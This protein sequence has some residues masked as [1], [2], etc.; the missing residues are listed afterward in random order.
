VAAATPGA[1]RMPKVVGM[2]LATA[3]EVIKSAIADPQFVVRQA[4][5]VGRPPGIVISQSPAAGTE[6][7]PGAEVRLAVADKTSGHP[8]ADAPSG[9]AQA[10]DSVRR[11]REPVAWAL[12]V[13]AAVM[14]LV[15]AGQLFG[16]PGLGLPI[17]GGPPRGLGPN[18]FALRASEAE[19]QFVDWIVIAPPLVSLVLVAF[20]GGLTKHA[21]QVLKT[22]AAV[23]AGTLVFGAVSLAGSTGGFQQGIQYVYEG[24]GLAVTATALIFTA[25]VIRSQAVR[26]LASR[27]SSN[28]L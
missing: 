8:G 27:E 10:W 15:S 4:S 9:T 21:R 7:N 1:S 20:S 3:Q 6:V 23:Q 16:V 14:V 12:L 22:V 17:C 28:Q 24:A 19:P 13:L 2:K 11:I 25:A 18:C 5:S 26:S